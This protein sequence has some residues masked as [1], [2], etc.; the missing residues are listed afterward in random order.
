[1]NGTFDIGA[2]IVHPS[3]TIRSSRSGCAA[4]PRS[5]KYPP[6]DVATTWALSRSSA[7]STSTTNPSAYAS[8]CSMR[9]NGA[10]GDRSA[11]NPD[12][13]P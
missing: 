13:P 7:S 6:Y 10:G 1:M 8:I 11:R 12:D 5:A 2:P 9:R 3:S 4:A